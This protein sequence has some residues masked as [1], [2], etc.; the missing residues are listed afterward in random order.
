M[1]FFLKAIGLSDDIP[2][3]PFTP[4]AND[5]GHVVY[6]SPLMC[7]TVRSGTP[8]D[9][10]QRKV[11]IF[12]CYLS[13]PSSAGN[14]ELA[15]LLARNAL[16]R[17][18]SLMIPGFLKCLG[19]TE[20][21]DTVYIATEVCLPLK[22]VL[23]SRE[24]RTQLCGTTPAEYDASVAYGISTVG[25]ALSSLHQ[26]RLVHGNVN[27]QS[28]FV[29]P[30]SGMWRLFGLELV[31][32][33][34]D[35][36]ANNAS[37]LFDSARR[38]GLLEGYRCPPEFSS[39][40]GSG[41]TGASADAFAIDSWGM[42]G[43]LYETVGVTADEALDGKLDSL[44]HTLASAELRNAC[45]QRLPQSLHSG[46]SGITAANPRLRKSVQA[47]LEHCEFVRS[48]V[49]VRYMKE[50][51]ELLL[52]DAA[53]QVRLAESL[54]DVVD[55]FPL[56]PC[57]CYVLPRLSELIRAAAKSGGASGVAGVSIGPVVDPFLKIA[58]RTSAGA[59]F[60]NY[61][62]PTLVHM[63]QSTDVLVRYKLLVGS[64]TY[65]G[66]L[67]SAALNNTIWPLYAK[68]FQ[69]PAPSVREYSARALVHLAPHLSEAVLG[70]QV[71]K[72]LGLLQRDP[73]GALRANATIA[74]HLIAGYITPPTQRATVILQSCR[75]MLRD[76]F[77]PSRV[78]ALRVIRGAMDCLSAKQLAEMVLP[79][80]APLTVDSTSEE[81]RSAAL[82]LVKSAMTKLEE[83]H[84]VLTAQQSA[85]LS[86]P[87]P[88]PAAAAEVST[89]GSGGASSWV[90]GLFHTSPAATASPTPPSTAPTRHV[91]ASSS[92][93]SSSLAI[94]PVAPSAHAT[95]VLP[96]PVVVAAAASA[97]GGGGSGWG[98]DEDELVNGG[99][100]KD[101]DGWGD[102]GDD[103]ADFAK[104]TSTTAA[105]KVKP[106]R[107]TFGAAAGA[108]SAP[109]RATTASFPGG[110]SLSSANSTSHTP[111]ISSATAAKPSPLAP[112]IN[113]SSTFTASPL[114]MTSNTS[115]ASGSSTPLGGNSSPR[116]AAANPIPPGPMKLRKKGGLGA[117]RLD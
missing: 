114:P 20:Y 91:E 3:F 48:S 32:S 103:D 92:S 28:V 113:S 82:A 11:S 93:A 49:F 88:A 94:H 51:S 108:G 50:L 89:S 70:D 46:C 86:S 60:D 77:E 73:D 45:R 107:S 14:N 57:L 10:A 55:S 84:R 81:S 105:M 16:R 35:V 24:L 83:N 79:W 78:A 101:D 1:A 43:L 90:W 29:L 64:E 76:A 40:S 85:T 99:D 37:C 80:V 111:T 106:L 66:K 39:G 68:G 31:S 33:P 4:E 5:P 21:R 44:V 56:R 6:T 34:D 26:N 27:C 116:V 19:A 97:A 112:R 75:P 52:L 41:G 67:A 13:A 87:A 17:A 8:H 54:T 65:S 63:Y 69:Y 47:F 58:A 98:S 7:W 110:A 71:P 95:T 117:A 42:A 109:A 12:T 22:E 104:P 102:D 25:G 100:A 15:K 74:L 115:N 61:V 18:K 38:A 30:S 72:A 23:E 62:T 53:Q 59:D 2:G 9:D 36:N 96:T